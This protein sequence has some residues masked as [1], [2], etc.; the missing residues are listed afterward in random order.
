MWRNKKIIWMQGY[1]SFINR[2]IQASATA[3]NESP[4]LHDK[5]VF[6]YGVALSRSVCMGLISN[7]KFLRKPKTFFILLTEREVIWGKLT[8][9]S[10][11]PKRLWNITKKPRV[12]IF[13]KYHPNYTSFVS[14]HW[15]PIA[16]HIMFKVLMLYWRTAKK[17][18]LFYLQCL[19]LIFVVWKYVP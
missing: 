10:W 18:A 15:L 16:A 12:F 9:T 6:G 3:S 11:N 14:V 1:Q 8:T 17:S 19:F 5:L 7:D 4:L 13:S 2:N